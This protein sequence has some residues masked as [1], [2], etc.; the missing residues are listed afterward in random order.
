M[1][2]SSINLTGSRS[3]FPKQIDTMRSLE[4]YASTE[5]G[6]T[7]GD[8][9]PAAARNKMG[10]AAIA[11]QK[12]LLNTPTVYGQSSDMAIATFTTTIEKMKPQVWYILDVPDEITDVFSVTNNNP[13]DHADRNML[14]YI[15]A[16]PIS[17]AQIAGYEAAV[18]AR[19]P[20]PMYHVDGNQLAVCI[21]AVP[22]EHKLGPDYAGTNIISTTLIGAI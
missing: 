4:N 8:R 16:R 22:A 19:T 1:S 17:A 15:D 3:R 12:S 5:S 14:V 2:T 18:I 20:R 11:I 7:W 13:L 6:A 10:D 21:Y 9:I